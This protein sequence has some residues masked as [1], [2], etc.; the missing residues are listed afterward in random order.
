[1]LSEDK[2]TCT[3]LYLTNGCF[4]PADKFSAVPSEILA[5]KSKSTK[6]EVCNCFVRLCRKFPENKLQKIFG[7]SFKQFTP[8]QLMACTVEEVQERLLQMQSSLL[9]GLKHPKHWKDFELES[10]E[11]FTAEGV[12]QQIKQFDL[13]VCWDEVEKQCRHPYVAL[14]HEPVIDVKTASWSESPAEQ[15]LPGKFKRLRASQEIETDFQVKQEPS[16]PVSQEPCASGSG[17][18]SEEH[19]VLPWEKKEANNT[20]APTFKR[21][22]QKDVNVKKKN[23]CQAQTK[24][25]AQQ[26]A[27]SKDKGYKE[28]VEAQRAVCE[29]TERFL[30]VAAQWVLAQ[31]PTPK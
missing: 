17:E 3:K 27:M 22:A 12:L 7:D 29:A 24:Y 11:A 28:L 31:K 30:N 4:Q 19:F 2:F 10:G 21:S 5:M 8:L 6:N 9:P 15:P 13:G 26:R 20:S 18:E 1:V 16:S 23:H 14:L 25:R